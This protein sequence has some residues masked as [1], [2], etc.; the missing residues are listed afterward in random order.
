VSGA[1]CKGDSN[2]VIDRLIRGVGGGIPGITF[3]V[4]NSFQGLPPK[5]QRD[6][7]ADGSNGNEIDGACLNGVV[8]VVLDR[9]ASK[10]ALEE[11]IFHELYG[12]S[13]LLKLFGGVRFFRA[14]GTGLCPA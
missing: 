7:L 11:T 6:A 1:V 12:H 2:E 14:A 5:V 8:Y 3:N 9:H 10:K 4:V 13:G